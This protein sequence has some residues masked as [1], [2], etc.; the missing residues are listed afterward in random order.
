MKPGHK[1]MNGWLNFVAENQFTIAEIE[2][3]TAHKTL[4][5]QQI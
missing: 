2:N 1:T 4:M 3:G 5:K